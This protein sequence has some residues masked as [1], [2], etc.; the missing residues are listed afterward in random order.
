M[1]S[2]HYQLNSSV[3]VVVFV[4]REDTDSTSLPKGQSHLNTNIYILF[5]S[6]VLEGKSYRIHWRFVKDIFL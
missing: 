1:A 5:Y 6:D 3:A 2:W 4:C